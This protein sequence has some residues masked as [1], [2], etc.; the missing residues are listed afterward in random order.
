MVLHSRRNCFSFM[1]KLFFF[2]GE[3]VFLLRR[4]HSATWCR[5]KEIHDNISDIVVT[6]SASDSLTV[7][8]GCGNG[9]FFIL[10]TYST[11]AH[12]R[13]YTLTISDF[14][15]DNKLDIAVANSGT[16]NI[17]LLYGL[18]EGFFG[19]EISYPLGYAYRPFS[20]AAEDLNG[21]GWTDLV[22]ACHGTDNI[23]VPM[24]MC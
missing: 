15:H 9:T 11:G 5:T 6:N 13:P 23:E 17:L 8:L 16:N 3:I 18:G 2:N 4:N 19:L 12:S 22:I 21:D 1:E 24:K 7:L 20:V 14:D 10:A